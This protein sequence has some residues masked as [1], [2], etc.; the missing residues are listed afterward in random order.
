MPIKNGKIQYNPPS[1]KPKR[2][3]KNR[4]NNP[5]FHINEG[6]VVHV[7]LAMFYPTDKLKEYLRELE[8]TQEI[9]YSKLNPNFHTIEKAQEQILIGL[10]EL[11]IRMVEGFKI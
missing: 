11:R 4:K 7:N 10:E 6:N 1:K 9:E 2:R 5:D 8:H 3:F